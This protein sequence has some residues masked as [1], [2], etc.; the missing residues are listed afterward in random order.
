M[1][2]FSDN[3]DNIK[4]I[5]AYFDCVWPKSEYFSLYKMLEKQTSWCHD[6]MWDKQRKKNNNVLVSL[7]IAKDNKKK[8][9]IVGDCLL[10]HL[11]SEMVN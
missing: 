8:L 9:N 1:I 10:D 3:L 7:I 6:K 11:T 5:F 4:T 2:N